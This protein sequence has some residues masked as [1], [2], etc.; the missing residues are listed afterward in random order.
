MTD[1]TFS[2]HIDMSGLIPAGSPVN[3]RIFQ[4]LAQAVNRIAQH[5]QLIWQAY[6]SGAALPDGRVIHIRTYAYKN[7]IKVRGTGEFSAEIYSDAAHAQA[8]E[9]GTRAYD[10]KRMLNT[11][12]L[13]RRTSTGKRYLIIPFR[14]GTPGATGFASVM[15]GSVYRM[16]RDLKPSS[17]IGQGFRASGTGAIDARTRKPF[18]VPQRIYRQPWGTRLSEGQLRE[19]GATGSTLR[20]QTGMVHFQNPAGSGGGKHG[21]FLTFRVMSESSPGWIR[22]ATPGYWPAKTTADRLRPIAEKAF[23]EAVKQDLL[24]MMGGG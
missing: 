12:M 22:K 3:G 17:V 24:S 19:A 23:A 1:N 20:H 4:S 8:L 16:W 7:S 10:M 9:S 6:A 21:N 11:S 5:G 15:S 14:H 18:M 13:V 2:I